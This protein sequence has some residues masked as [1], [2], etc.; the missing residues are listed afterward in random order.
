MGW[1]WRRVRQC[2]RTGDGADRRCS[3]HHDS[4]GPGTGRA[5]GTRAVAKQLYRL[6]GGHYS[7]AGGSYSKSFH[8][9]G[10][11][12]GSRRSLILPPWKIR[13]L[14]LD[15]LTVTAMALVA[16]LMAAAAQ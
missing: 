13:T 11:R 4:G 10:R 3:P 12:N 6:L 16:L 14:P 15:S 5:S 7:G 1:H 9:M 2:L 8:F